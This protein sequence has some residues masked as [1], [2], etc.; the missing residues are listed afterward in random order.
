MVFT[1]DRALHT[2]LVRETSRHAFYDYICWEYLVGDRQS[3]HFFEEGAIQRHLDMRKEGSPFTTDEL[4]W[5]RGKPFH[6][7]IDAYDAIVARWCFPTRSFLIEVVDSLSKC[8]D[9]CFS[10]ANQ[11]NTE[12]NL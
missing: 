3:P 2:T 4:V 11:D 1:L 8:L 7:A 6:E 5:G 12:R 9:M 10:F